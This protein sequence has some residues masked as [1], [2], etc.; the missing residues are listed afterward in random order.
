VL[1][2]HPDPY[3]TLGRSHPGWGSR[4]SGSGRSWIRSH[5]QEIL[6]PHPGGCSIDQGWSWVMVRSR[7]RWGIG[8]WTASL[9]VPQG[10]AARHAGREDLSESPVLHQPPS[11][12]PWTQFGGGTAFHFVMHE[13][14][15]S[16]RI[17]KFTASTDP[18]DEP[19]PS[20]WR[21]DARR[22]SR[23]RPRVA[24]P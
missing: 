12:W 8:Q 20:G 24:A 23:L 7:R 4:P 9:G 14:R 2:V 1:R 11:V 13:G 19:R 16:S 3:G 22:L 10:S 15:A 17:R 21:P 18:V 5:R 6:R